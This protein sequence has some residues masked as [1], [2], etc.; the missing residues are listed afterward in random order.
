MSGAIASM[1]SSRSEGG[2]F[3]NPKPLESRPEPL[4]Q[5]L[6][7]PLGIKEVPV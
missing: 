4:Q 7:P 5:E 1:E 3:Y 2:G 6:P